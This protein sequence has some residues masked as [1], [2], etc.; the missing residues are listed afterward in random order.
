MGCFFKGELYKCSCMVY[1]LTNDFTY[2]TQ[3]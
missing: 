3:Q 2:E 1:V